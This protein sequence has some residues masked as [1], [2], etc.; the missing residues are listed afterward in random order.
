[1]V[2]PRWDAARSADALAPLA[3][4]AAAGAPGDGLVVVAWSLG[5]MVA[6]EALPA[7][8]GRVRAL[9]LVAPCLSFT[10]GWPRRVLERMRRRCA[11]D[12][13]ATLAAFAGALLAPGEAGPP[14]IRARADQPVAALQAGLD[15]LATRAL[16]PPAAPPGCAVRVIHG[17]ADP[18]IAAALSAPV[19]AALGAARR[20]LPGAG[21]APQCTRAAECRAFLGEEAAR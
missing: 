2:S 5:A 17:G 6:L 16:A 21:H 18:I 20:V 11:D 4:E 14:L 9:L 7:L 12:P 3:L 15:Y 8:A 19:A 10:A 13:A 1:V